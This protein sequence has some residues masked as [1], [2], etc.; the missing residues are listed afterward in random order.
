MKTLEKWC[1]SATH[2]V[3]LRKNQSNQSKHICSADTLKDFDSLDHRI[4]LE[5]LEFM[6]SGACFGST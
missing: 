6:D 4:L 5:K 1:N 2:R 3:Q